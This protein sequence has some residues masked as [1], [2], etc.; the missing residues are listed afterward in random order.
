[1]SWVVLALGGSV[2]LLYGFACGVQ[3]CS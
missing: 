1:M 2:F 3:N